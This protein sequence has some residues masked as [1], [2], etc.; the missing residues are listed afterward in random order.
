MLFRR[1]RGFGINSGEVDPG[2]SFSTGFGGSGI[3]YVAVWSY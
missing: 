3:G 2:T 1:E